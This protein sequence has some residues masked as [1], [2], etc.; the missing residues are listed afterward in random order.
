MQISKYVIQ[1]VLALMLV[2]MFAFGHEKGDTSPVRQVI[3]A[4]NIKFAAAYNSHDAAGVAAIYTEDATTLPPYRKMV[5][6]RA[7]IHKANQ[8][9]FDSG[10]K[11]LQ[12]STVSLE[13]HGDFAYE[14]GKYT[15]T[16]PPQDNKVMKDTGKY[17]AIWKK[18]ADGS[19]KIYMDTW[20]SSLPLP[21][22]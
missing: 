2:P 13:V 16:L 1:V 3:D 21:G 8:D 20:N 15:I 5:Q 22:M 12:L 6:G 19:W 14:I 17:L 7:A 18:Q 11:D 9:E 4:Q 10:L